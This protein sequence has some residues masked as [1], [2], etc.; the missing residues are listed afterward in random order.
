[1]AAEKDRVSGT[2]GNGF[3]EL[4]REARQG[5]A[6]DI[7]KRS[8]EWCIGQGWTNEEATTWAK[9]AEESFSIPRRVVR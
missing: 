1:M 4:D 3:Y 5:V 8:F 6:S 7:A 9:A 2:N